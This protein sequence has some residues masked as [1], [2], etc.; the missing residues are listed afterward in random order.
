MKASATLPWV[1]LFAMLAACGGGSDGTSAPEPVTTT[2][3][4]SAPKA[5]VNEA[6]TLTWSSSHATACAIP[7]RWGGDW[8]GDWR[9]HR[10][11]LRRVGNH[12]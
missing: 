2:A 1:F 10:L 11:G 3:S 6:V 7:I 4:L 8:D 5:R 9:R 12:L